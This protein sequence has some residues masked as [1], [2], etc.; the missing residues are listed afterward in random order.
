MLGSRDKSKASVLL[1]PIKFGNWSI[2]F[3]KH[4]GF[5]VRN[6]KVNQE[7]H[8]HAQSDGWL[9]GVYKVNP[10]KPGMIAMNAVG[11]CIGQPV[12]VDKEATDKAERI[13]A[14]Q[15]IARSRKLTSAE[16]SELLEISGLIPS[17]Q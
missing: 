16:Q 3:N 13:V 6:T 2:E 15:E 11:Q 1:E 8:F 10:K 12:L 17:K 14:L 4:F 7:Y 5:V 9:T